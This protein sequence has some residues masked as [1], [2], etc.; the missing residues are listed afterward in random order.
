MRPQLQAGR[1][2]NKDPA[3]VKSHT[4]P[5]GG[6]EESSPISAKTRLPATG[7]R[8]QSAGK[9]YTLKEEL[10]FDALV[11][12]LCGEARLSPKDVDSSAT[13]PGTGYGLGPGNLGVTMHAEG[14][15]VLRPPVRGWERCSV[16]ILTQYCW[17]NKPRVEAVLRAAE[18]E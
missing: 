2:V 6:L 14:V 17:K 13:S 11:P 16:G 4:A 1:L 10:E 5:L 7:R 12:F 8:T 18:T 3:Q 9:R 15:E